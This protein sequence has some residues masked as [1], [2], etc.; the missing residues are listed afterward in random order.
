[1]AD[2]NDTSTE[3]DQKDTAQQGPND[4]GGQEG[5]DDATRQ[6]HEDD[7]RQEAED[8][9]K[10]LTQA[11]V[12]KQIEA[13]LARERRKFADYDDLKKK[14]TEF[15]KLQEGQKTEAQK[16]NDRLAAQSIELQELRVEKIRRAAV[17]AAGLDPEMAEF[18]TA[19]DENEAAE[20]A[21]KLADRL[22]PSGKQGAPDF[23]Q[24][25][26]NTPPPQ[27]S[28]DDLLRGLAGYGRN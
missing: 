27:R 4:N 16:L 6:Q 22:K 24:G 26:R 12:D 8:K 18:I 19:A 3:G 5:R 21:K 10:T 15:D 28:R 7:V 17:S 2:E 14:A 20:Q 25:T 1:M 13:R 23:K 11:E 9:G